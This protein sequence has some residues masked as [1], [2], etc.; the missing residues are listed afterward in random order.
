MTGLEG[1]CPAVSFAV[2][3]FTIYT[4]AETRFDGGSCRSLRNGREVEVDGMLMSD[5]RVRASRVDI[6]D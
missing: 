3:G 1:T 6:D 5:G 2:N 4:T